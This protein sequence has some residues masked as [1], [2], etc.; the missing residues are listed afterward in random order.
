M[1]KGFTH[2]NILKVFFNNYTSN[3][4]LKKEGTFE[5]LGEYTNISLGYSDEINR[6]LLTLSEKPYNN[7]PIKLVSINAETY[8]I[9]NQSISD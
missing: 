4:R 2:K 8:E 6:F 3:T 1:D 7:A 5:S 9:E